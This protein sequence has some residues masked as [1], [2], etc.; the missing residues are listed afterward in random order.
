MKTKRKDEEKKL[1]F[2]CSLLKIA[3]MNEHLNLTLVPYRSI[4]H[5]VM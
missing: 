2:I 1:I 5:V 4:H 3:G